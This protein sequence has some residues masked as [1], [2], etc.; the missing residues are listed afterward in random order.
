MVRLSDRVPWNEDWDAKRALKGSLE[1]SKE[2][3]FRQKEA[4]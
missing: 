2:S 1:F 4:F 3:N